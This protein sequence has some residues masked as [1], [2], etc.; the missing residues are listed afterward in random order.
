MISADTVVVGIVVVVIVVFIFN[1]RFDFCL[2]NKK[3][4]LYR[5]W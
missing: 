3:K 2:E 1:T 5:M 4:T